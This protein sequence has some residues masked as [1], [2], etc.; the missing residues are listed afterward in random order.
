MAQEQQENRQP[1]RRPGSDR[2]A[3][4]TLAGL[5]WPSRGLADPQP[6][7]QPCALQLAVWLF[8]LTRGFI[9]GC[10][11]AGQSP[12]LFYPHDLFTPVG[13][14]KSQRNQNRAREMRA[15]EKNPETHPYGGGIPHNHFC[16]FYN[17]F[18]AP[19]LRF[20]IHSSRRRFCRRITTLPLCLPSKKTY[21][22]RSKPNPST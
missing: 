5:H 18:L 4:K 14:N 16:A 7:H 12:G 13:V 11:G 6:P 15:R 17:Y 10:W 21:R 1:H 22:S 3:G 2:V 8:G 20:R 19:F 9:P